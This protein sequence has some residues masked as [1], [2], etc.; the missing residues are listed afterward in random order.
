M[1]AAIAFCFLLV[2]AATTSS[3]VYAQQINA[4]CVAE[5]RDALL[6]FRAGI[7]SDPQNLLAS[8]NGQDCCQWSGVKCSNSTGH[9]IKLDLRN[10]FFLDDLYGPPADTDYPHWMHGKI[11]SSLLALHHLKYL[12]LSGNHFGGVGVPIPRFLGYFQSLIYLNLSSM[13]FDGPVPPQLGNLS[14][15]QY[16]DIG[17]NVWNDE[18]VL[19]NSEDISWLTRLPLLRFL[20]MSGVSLSTVD[21]WVQVV[22]MLFN[23]RALRL[24]YCELVFPYTP[25]VH[26]NL[27]SLEMVYLRDNGVNTLNPTCWFWHAGTIRHLDLTN[28]M[29]DGALPDAVGNMTSL[30]VLHL[31]GNQLSDVKAKPLKNL[32]SLR[33]LR[34]S[35]NGINQDLSD[36]LDELPPCSWSKLQVLDLSLTN[37]SGEIP[38][39]INRWTDLGVLQLSSNR[40]LGSVPLEIGMLSKLDTLLLDGNQFNGSISEEHLASLVNLKYLDLSYNSLHMMINL[41]WIPPFKLQMAYFTRCKMGSH[42]PLWLKGQ[43]DV[44][45]LDISDAGIVDNLPDWFWT[46]FSNV[47]Y[48]NISCNQINGRLPRTLEF[49]SSAL[50]FDLNSNNVTGSLPELP[51]NLQE[52]DISKNS[53][54]GPL[55]QK[56]G[57]PYLLNLLLSENDINGTI[58]AYICQLQY[59]RVL[60]LA[61]NHL[62]G[63]LPLCSAGSKA[64]QTSIS[65][66]ILYNN[67]M[68]GKFPLFLL[69]CPDL[70]L[71]DLAH[72]KYTGELPTWIANKLPRLSY[73]QLRNNMFSGSIPVQLTDLQYLQFLDLAQNRISGS[74]PHSLANLNAMTQNQDHH[75]TL[76]NPLYWSW[77]N[78]NGRPSNSDTYDLPKYA[79]SLELI[80]KGQYLDYTSNIIY[81]I[82]LDLSHNNL[83]GEIP[84][85]ITSLI[86][87]MVFNLSH[88]Q[89]SGRIPEK[90]GLLRS[91][92]SLDLS[93][94]ELYG[95][96]PYSLSD[97]TMLSNMNL[98]YNNLSGT[99]PTGNQLQALIDPASSY[100]GNKYLCGPPI[101]RNCSGPEI[102]RG[103]LDEPQSDSEVRYL[104][105]GMAVGFVLGLWLVFVTFL[106]ARTWRTTYFQLCDKLLCSVETFFTPNFRMYLVKLYGK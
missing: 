90:I 7:T 94:N 15:L 46:V 73:L 52:L 68:S 75:Q 66:L 53:L 59:L 70:V 104:Y 4:E 79:D 62:A 106:F 17:Y 20:D 81:M 41:N 64:T 45:I 44:I 23:L 71:L 35:S 103:Y 83:V 60:D 74:I 34:L 28:N 97:M 67:N 82:A 29:I 1:D 51:R 87:M 58:P 98:S 24:G 85:E 96:I 47:V 2:L 95:E 88:N 31:G 102:A 65:A 78:D 19:L 36:F 55:P 63:Q 92:E 54:S 48:L 40:L 56:F 30:E 16:L 22:N 39:W 91:L 5:E 61:K 6:S 18:G 37:V 77:N 86:G 8:W 105:I 14:R 100:I 99:I 89:L 43:H 84:D 32:C 12:D 72:N 50:I 49:M 80:A 3:S 13:D 9:V 69:S 93:W 11:S 25:I 26:I 27:T 57:A 10:N 42:F 21:H 33:E 76:R 38:N 101:S